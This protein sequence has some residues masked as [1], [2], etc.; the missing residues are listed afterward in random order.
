MRRSYPLYY[1]RALQ[2]FV[3]AYDL[4]MHSDT[5]WEDIYIHKTDPTGSAFDKMADARLKLA[6]QVQRMKRTGKY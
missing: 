6:R 2:R 3:K 1:V 4:W 5:T